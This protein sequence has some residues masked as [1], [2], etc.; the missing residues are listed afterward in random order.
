MKKYV[1]SGY[2]IVD[3]GTIDTSQQSTAEISGE[4]AEVIKSALKTK[5]PILLNIDD[6][7]NGNF[8]CGFCVQTGS[9]YARIIVDVSL[10]QMLSYS[11]SH[12]P[13]DK[14]TITY[15]YEEV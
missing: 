10:S 14:V 7:G 8:V 1:P 15:N 11:I 2:V 4:N 9:R 6:D 13:E 3:L 5:K 12:T